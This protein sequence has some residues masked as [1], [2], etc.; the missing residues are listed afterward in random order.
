MNP[1]D[2]RLQRNK[3]SSRERGMA[4]L[5]F[6]MALPML[7]L[8]L[9]GGFEL[10][11]YILIVQKVDNIAH[12]VADIAA[13][14]QSLTNAD[15]NDIM[16]AAA[17]IMKPYPFSTAGTV[18]VSSVY[19]DN[20]AS[21]AQAVRWRRTGGGTL[22]RS[23]KIG[24]VSA[25]AVLPNGLVLNDKENVLVTEVY[26]AYVPAVAADV[27]VAGDIYKAAIF[28]PRLGTLITPPA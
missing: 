20:A 26:Y 27:M 3:R 28:K 6:A 25:T 13:Q 22:V 11:R 17:E 18:I 5:E 23:S 12:S 19:R 14:A 16:L 15:I 24:N 4:A 8:M 1:I 2:F 7:V 10:A 9:L 21:P